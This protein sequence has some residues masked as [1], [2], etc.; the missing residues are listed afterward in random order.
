M[1][2]TAGSGAA[3]AVALAIAAACG[4]GGSATTDAR[5]DD[6]DRRAMLANLAT[7]VIAPAYQAFALGAGELE[8]A[9]AAW[10]D[11]V[12]GDAAREAARVAW[13]DAMRAWQHA[14]VMLVGPAAMDARALRD[15]VHSWPTT[16]TCAVDQEVNMVAVDPDAYDISAKTPNRRGLP[17]LEYV[18]FTESL[19]HTCPSQIEPTGWDG[20]AQADR[21]AAR[22]AYAAAAA[23]DVAAT[24]RAIA[25]GWSSYATE[26]SAGDGSSLTPQAAA[27]LISDAMFYLDTDTKDMKLGEPAGIVDNSCGAIEEACPAELESPHARHSK[28]NVSA[29]L[30]AFGRLY[31]GDQD[32]PGAGLGFDEFLRALGGVALADQMTASIAA[33]GEAVVAIPGTLDAAITDDRDAVAD[34][35]AAV[36]TVTDDLKSQFLTILGL[37]APDGAAGD[38]D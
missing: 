36:K 37:D 35:H 18:L 12:D 25:D 8:S 6:F 34:A 22:C 10:C 9:A 32:G 16:S 1:A 4:G 13:R 30:I 11:E 31:H 24:G 21:L 20:L 38:N 28:E 26:L 23:A 17:A 19:E 15:Q 5:V 27:N 7:N 14:E 29:N 3:A 33:A 2:R